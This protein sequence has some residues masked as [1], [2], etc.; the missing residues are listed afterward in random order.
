MLLAGKPFCSPAE[1]F[2]TIGRFLP[3]QLSRLKTAGQGI[4][5][6]ETD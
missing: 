4:A 1:F 2:N 6:I 5:V 3:Y